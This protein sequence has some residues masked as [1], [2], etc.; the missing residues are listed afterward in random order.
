MH[1]LNP[2]GPMMQT[3]NLNLLALSAIALLC[4][5]VQGC[6][7]GWMTRSLNEQSA[8]CRSC[9]S[10]DGAAGARDFS[11]VYAPN[12][13]HHSVGVEFPQDAQAGAKF[14]Q[15][16][17]KIG[18]VAFFDRNGNGQP[19]GDEVQLFG[20]KG[21]VK[22][23]CASCHRE[24]GG[25]PASAVRHAGFQLRIDNDNSALCLVCHNI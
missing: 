4:L 20:G 17:G 21:A 19:D 15:P 8:I 10:P 3:S 18:N 11:S 5:L 23:E 13:I 1:T 9:H 7:Q 16:N 2:R 24:H 6:A 14:K 25:S 22:V 12:T